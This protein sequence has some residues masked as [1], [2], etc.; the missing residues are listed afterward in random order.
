MVQKQ[1]K[2]QEVTGQTLGPEKQ[3]CGARESLRDPA[4][5]SK[6]T[7]S[8]GEASQ[9]LVFGSPLHQARKPYSSQQLSIE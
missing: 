8:T 3:S 6:H 4:S 2:S 7:I 1:G 5:S 9:E